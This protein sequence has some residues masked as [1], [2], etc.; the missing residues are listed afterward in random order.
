MVLSK[1]TEMYPHTNKEIRK[2]SQKITHHLPYNREKQTELPG[3]AWTPGRRV[4]ER[5][6]AGGVTSPRHLCWRDRRK[7]TRHSGM[8]Q[9]TYLGSGIGPYQGEDMATHCVT[10]ISMCQVHVVP[11]L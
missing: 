4:G 3:K 11:T 2:Y 10:N 7:S 6:A 5:P 8:I 1:Q 9:G